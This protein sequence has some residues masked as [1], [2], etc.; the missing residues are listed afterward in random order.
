MRALVQRVSEAGVQLE[1]AQVASIGTGLLVLLGV[2]HTDSEGE[3]AK[4]AAKVAKLRIFADEAGKMNR[5]V[6]EV[7]GAALVVSQFTLYG[8]A[9]GG[10]RPSFTQAARP[11]QAEALYRRFCQALEAQGVP[12]QTGVFAA[13]MNVSLVNQGP[14]TLWLDSEQL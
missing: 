13:D 6:L 4:L 3:A 2:T 9:K 8:N 12:V 5:S 1:G 14:V 11:E 10:N 7:S